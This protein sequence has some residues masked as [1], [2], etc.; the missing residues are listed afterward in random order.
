MKVFFRVYSMQRTSLA[1]SNPDA[2]STGMIA[3]VLDEL[4]TF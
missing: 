3:E 4:R 2:K 1:K